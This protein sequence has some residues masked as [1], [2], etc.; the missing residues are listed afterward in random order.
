M[1]HQLYIFV[2]MIFIVFAVAFCIIGFAIDLIGPGIFEQILI[3][4]GIPISYETFM[5]FGCVFLAITTLFFIC[6]HFY[7][8]KKNK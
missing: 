2:N 1:K 6:E 7:L 4:L 5:L 3:N 8:K